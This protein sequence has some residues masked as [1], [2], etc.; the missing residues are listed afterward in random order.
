MPRAG[1]TLLQRILL[2]HKSIGGT[3]EPWLLLPLVYLNKKEG[4][5]SEYSSRLS[6]KAIDDVFAEVPDADRFFNFQIKNSSIYSHKY[7]A[8]K[9]GVI[10]FDVDEKYKS[11][12]VRNLCVYIYI[13]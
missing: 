8:I 10:R 9:L 12:I 2:S 4:V 6:S 1:S 13:I 7:C 5:L 11:L 3:A